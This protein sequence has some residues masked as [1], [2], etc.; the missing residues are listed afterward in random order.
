MFRRFGPSYLVGLLVA[1]LVIV[2]LS[3]RVATYLRLTLGYGNPLD[4]SRF[5]RG[6]V[7]PDLYLQLAVGVLWLGAFL[8]AEL[9]N[10]RRIL[11][12]YHEF[13]RLILAHAVA[14]LVLA[15]GFYW[16]NRQLPRLLYGYFFLVA[17][18]GLLGYRVILRA[19]HRLRAHRSE[20]GVLRVLIVGAGEAGRAVLRKLRE[21]AWAGLRCVGFLDDDTAKHGQEV[22]GVPVLG[23]LAEAP[24]VVGR[25]GVEEVVIA[26]PGYAH[27]R[28]SQL[29]AALHPLP[30]RVRVVP[31]YFSIALFGASV[32][33]LGGIPMIGLRD[34][35]IDGFQR[36]VKR[37]MDL[38][39]SAAALV[40]FAPL[41]AF[42]AAAIKL[43]DGGPVFYRSQRVGE[44][45]RLFEMLKFRSMCPDAE[46]RIHDV[47]ERD[48][49]GNVIHK[50]PHDP[51]VTRVGRWLRKTSLDELPQL[52][53]VL[54]GDMSLVGPRPEL[55]W[56]V[57]KYQPWQRKRFAVPQGLTGWWQ[58]NGR[59]DKPMHLHSEEDLF[60]IQNYSLWLD[61]H[62]LWKTIF[63]VLRGRGAF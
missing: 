23:S 7:L 5:P 13:Q 4:P 17:L 28:L 42:I 26:L 63:V 60:Y 43:E 47:V 53:N 48:E 56:L 59:A 2:Q 15:G 11:R 34:P 21:R 55:P 38:G 8:L 36:L 27:E 50:K 49:H 9:Y 35:A 30:V 14:A 10:P 6:V 31:D 40:V 37:L 12:W 19:W 25:L 22:E 32:E 61:L 58:I 45:G 41:M 29:V 51:R 62:I 57:E 3:L 39:L 33:T 16:A 52:W 44:N 24:E 18:A 20:A 54:K 46:R 1:D